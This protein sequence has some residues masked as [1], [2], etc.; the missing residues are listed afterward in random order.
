MGM[1]LIIL[2]FLKAAKNSDVIWNI[3][4]P[5]WRI[6][7]FTMVLMSM[8]TL[9]MLS[10]TVSNKNHEYSYG[11][12]KDILDE[13]L[14][15]LI[16]MNKGIELNAGGYHY[17][18]GEP[19]PCIDVIRRYRELGG[20]IITVGADAHTPDKI[21]WEF[22]KTANVLNDCGFRYYTIFKNRSPEFLPL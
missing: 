18:L 17:G 11:R 22:A 14:K 3:L 2:I 8:D 5:S 12:Y 4:N 16:S 7:L 13:I 9:T 20:E 6:C 10:D 15:K 1:T 21:A 19:N